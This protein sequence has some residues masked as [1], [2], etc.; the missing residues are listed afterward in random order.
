MTTANILSQLAKT[1]FF[2]FV[3]IGVLI[4]IYS[5]AK[6]RHGELFE[7]AGPIWAAAELAIAIIIVLLICLYNILGILA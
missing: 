2:A 1:A 6:S 4:S 3:A 7:E 5:A